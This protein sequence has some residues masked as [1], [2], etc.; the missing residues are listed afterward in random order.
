MIQNI[1]YS[2]KVIYINVSVS[3]KDN[4]LNDSQSNKNIDK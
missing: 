4:N 3:N 1:I 2:A